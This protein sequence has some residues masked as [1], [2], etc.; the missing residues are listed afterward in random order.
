MAA[1]AQRRALLGLKRAS[2]LGCT[3]G[4]TA[5][6]CGTLEADRRAGR[7][8]EARCGSLQHLQLAAQGLD[9]TQ[10]T[11]MHAD[12]PR[13]AHLRLLRAVHLHVAHLPFLCPQTVDH[14]MDGPMQ[15]PGSAA[16]A[17]H[18]CISAC[19]SLAS[20]AA[21]AS[22]QTVHSSTVCPNW[23]SGTCPTAAVGTCPS[24]SGLA[25]ALA[26]RSGRR[27]QRRSTIQG[28]CAS[29]QRPPALQLAAT[30]PPPPLPAWL[31][32]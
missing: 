30:H 1:V 5:A 6:A 15:R 4:W 7:G 22:S 23:R 3:L 8:R 27:T 9:A 14:R 11:A 12:A 18:C 29:T 16:S 26:G 17:A 25:C 24:L 13:G 32:H 31:R 10:L 21:S 19:Q 2:A 28:N 20:C